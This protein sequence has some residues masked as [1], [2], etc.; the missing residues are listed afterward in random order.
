MLAYKYNSTVVTFQSFLSPLIYVNE[1][2]VGKTFNAIIDQHITSFMPSFF[3]FDLYD[4]D[5]TDPNRIDVNNYCFI[6]YSALLL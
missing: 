6:Y 2:I 4:Q 1:D 5:T 3:G